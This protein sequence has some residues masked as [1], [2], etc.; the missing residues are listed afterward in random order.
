MSFH[1]IWALDRL[2]DTHFHSWEWLCL[3]SLSI[4]CYSLPETQTCPDMFYQLFGNPLAQSS[5]HT[6]LTNHKRLKTKTHFACVS[7]VWAKL[8]REISLFYSAWA[9]ATP[10]WAVNLPPRW[11]TLTVS[12][13]GPAAGWKVTWGLWGPQSVP[14]EAS[15]C[16]LGFFTAWWL[17][18]RVTLSIEIARELYLSLCSLGGHIDSIALTVTKVT[19]VQG[20][21]TLTS[22]LNRS[23]KLL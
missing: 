13:S 10:L 16:V 8:S 9:V 6:K 7:A 11:V 15:S 19:Q 5:W 20:E 1:C 12:K 14:V 23:G 17:G 21:E 22:F 2:N 4:Q 3:F 18:S